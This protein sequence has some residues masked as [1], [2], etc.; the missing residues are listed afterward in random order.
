M[1][2]T[3]SDRSV[4]LAV[5]QQKFNRIIWP[6]PTARYHFY[7][8]HCHIVWQESTHKLLQKI[9]SPILRFIWFIVLKLSPFCFEYI[10][11]AMRRNDA[12]VL[13]WHSRR[14]AI[15]HGKR[16]INFH[17]NTKIRLK[18]QTRT[19]WTEADPNKVNLKR[20]VKLAPT[21][22]PGTPA[23][24]NQWKRLVKIFLY[25]LGISIY[26]ANKD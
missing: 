24:I 11:F 4:F 3:P 25:F 9:D 10:A 18:S 1:A 12:I 15:A 23:C 2:C 17:W 21:P 7:K 5:C 19:K 26:G 6:H 20:L 22:A 16:C 13:Y 8:K 14:N